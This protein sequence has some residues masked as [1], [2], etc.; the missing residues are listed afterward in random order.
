MDILPAQ[1]NELIRKRRSVFPKTYN[2]KP[3]S[4][5]IVEEILENANWAPTHKL[6][7]PWRFKVIVGEGLERLSNFLSDHYKSITPEEKFS[8]VK[9]NKL[10][11]NP[12][13][14]ACVIAVC[15]KR[16]EEERVAEWEEIAAV[17]CAVQ[18]MYLTCT[19]Y[20]I[21]CYWSTPKVALEADEFLGLTN[22]ERCLGLF[23][24][25]YHDL[26]DLPGKRNPVSEKTTWIT[27]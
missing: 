24:M 16:D 2:S 17:A 1:V 3:I 12:L 27:E 19:A 7:E 23:Y 26:P 11:S 8:E 25:G 15:M 22:S 10:K 14:A 9:Y 5:Q 4:R 13:K 18:N 6:T 21:G 20:G